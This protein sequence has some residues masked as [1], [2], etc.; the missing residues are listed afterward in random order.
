MDNVTFEY[1]RIAILFVVGVA[2]ILVAIKN[3]LAAWNQLTGKKQKAEQEEAQNARIKSLED[4]RH[5]CEERLQR[6]DEKFDAN[7]ADMTMILKT[8]STI[9]MPLYSGNDH[10]TLRDTIGELNTYLS[11]RR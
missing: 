6:G 8:L 9:L 11:N 5:E 1:L 2:G 4:W 3:G 7:S 10:E